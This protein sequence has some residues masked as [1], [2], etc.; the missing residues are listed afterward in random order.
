[1]FSYSAN[2]S[3]GSFG[4]FVA[5]RLKT[6]MSVYE[7]Q[8]VLCDS[9]EDVLRAALYGVIVPFVGFNL[10]KGI[11]RHTYERIMSIFE[12]RSEERKVSLPITKCEACTVWRYLVLSR[13]VQFFQLT[14]NCAG[15]IKIV[16]S[17]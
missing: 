5:F 1:M 7:H 11:F 14:G 8:L 3:C 6:G 12:D 13:I 15:L 16:G 2:F 4:W 10:L 9:E 17:S